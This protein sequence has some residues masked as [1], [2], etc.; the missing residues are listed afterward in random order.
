MN[1]YFS[2]SSRNTRL[3]EKYSRFRLEKL[4]FHSNFVGFH[5]LTPFP[6]NKLIQFAWSDGIEPILVFCKGMIGQNSFAKP[7]NFSGGWEEASEVSEN[8][9]L[10][11]W[12]PPS[13]QASAFCLPRTPDSPL[14]PES[15]KCGLAKLNVGNY[16]YVQL[17]FLAP[18]YL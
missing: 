1:F 14:C 15:G 18:I 8:E 7:K 9:W 4:D 16:I 6:R 12:F 17:I 2:F 10:C 11:P 5:Y 3:I 13:V